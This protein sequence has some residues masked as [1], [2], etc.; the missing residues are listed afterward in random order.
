MRH[1]IG[2]GPLPPPACSSV[3]SRDSS[4]TA[5][6]TLQTIVYPAYRS[7]E[8]SAS[9]LRPHTRPQNPPHGFASVVATSSA[10]SLMRVITHGGTH[11]VIACC[12]GA[13]SASSLML[14]GF[15]VRSVIAYLSS[16]LSQREDR[17]DGKI[18]PRFRPRSRVF[19]HGNMFTMSPLSD[20]LS[21]GRIPGPHQRLLG[22][23]PHFQAFA[24]R[25]PPS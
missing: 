6:G 21:L 16:G 10:S 5:H 12:S 1:V 23:M 8:S 17:H 9:S 19:E 13:S 7:G 25:P 22:D 4:L 11:V 3:E 2:I 15:S 24:A 18:C 20:D 14:F